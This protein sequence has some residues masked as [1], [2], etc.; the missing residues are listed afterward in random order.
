MIVPLELTTLFTPRPAHPLPRPRPRSNVVYRIPA[1][2]IRRH[3]PQ[4][5]VRDRD[6]GRIGCRL[7]V[8]MG[9]VP[10]ALDAMGQAESVDCAGDLLVAVPDIQSG[11]QDASRRAGRKC[12]TADVAGTRGPGMMADLEAHAV[13]RM[14]DGGAGAGGDVGDRWQR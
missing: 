9:H 8:G 6:H 3:V 10:G 2:A 5:Q 14:V 4:D 11:Y 1:Y 12:T 13:L 7:M